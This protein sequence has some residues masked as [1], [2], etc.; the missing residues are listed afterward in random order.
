[1][2]F[3]KYLESSNFGNFE[4]LLETK[5]LKTSLSKI[6]NFEISYDIA[7]TVLTASTLL[8][9]FAYI[10]AI[11]YIYRNLP[12]RKNLGSGVSE[13][14]SP[15]KNGVSILKSLTPESKTLRNIES[16]TEVQQRYIN[17]FVQK[18]FGSRRDIFL[19]GSLNFYIS[20]KFWRCL[21]YTV[22]ELCIISAKKIVYD[23]PEII[24]NF[25]EIIRNFPEI[26]RNFGDKVGTS[27]IF[28]HHKIDNYVKVYSKLFLNEYKR[29]ESISSLYSRILQN[30]HCI[31]IEC[32]Q[33]LVLKQILS[34]VE[35]FKDF[36]GDK[37]P[38]VV[39]MS[40]S[41]SKTFESFWEFDL[42]V[43]FKK[44]QKLNYTIL[45]I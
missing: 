20:K 44:L 30:L 17:K 31:D 41:D 2:S 10:R 22:A 3:L 14:T 5:S 26:I 6:S 11:K 8:L 12:V 38:K 16:K 21:E 4:T 25:P 45:E 9:F 33:K 27:P 32:C 29:K 34:S 1:M 7:L 18:Q 36:V 19:I 37:V 15:S 42:L 43:D 39:S 13:T 28:Y 23:F 40:P 24:H 35:S